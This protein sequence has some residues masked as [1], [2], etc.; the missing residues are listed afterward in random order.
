MSGLESVGW[1]DSARESLASKTNHSDD[2]SV[3]PEFLKELFV[4]EN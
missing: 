1:Q 3:F 4:D 2:Q